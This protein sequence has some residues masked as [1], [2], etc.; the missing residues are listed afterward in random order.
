MLPV[1]GGVV[2]WWA[3]WERWIL[4][5]G[6]EAGEWKKGDW[7]VDM[8]YILRIAWGGGVTWV[9]QSVARKAAIEEVSW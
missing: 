8:P 9:A 7:K 3:I 6:R 5:L 4:G 2:R 1:V